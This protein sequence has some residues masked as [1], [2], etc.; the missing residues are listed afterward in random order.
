MLQQTLDSLQAGQ[1]WFSKRSLD[2]FGDLVTSMTQY[3][4]SDRPSASDVLQHS[5]FRR[6]PDLLYTPGEIV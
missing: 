6:G 1:L 3:R 5:W 4:P 2:D